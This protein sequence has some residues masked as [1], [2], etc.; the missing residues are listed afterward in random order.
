MPKF[1]SPLNNIT[2]T[3]SNEEYLSIRLN[4]FLNLKDMPKSFYE[5][6]KG[7]IKI[8]EIL[9]ITNAAGLSSNMFTNTLVGYK[10]IINWLRLQVHCNNPYIPAVTSYSDIN[11]SI[12]DTLLNGVESFLSS[13]ENDQ[14]YKFI[15]L[16]QATIVNR[17]FN[18]VKS[19]SEILTNELEKTYDERKEDIV[20]KSSSEVSIQCL[21][22]FSTSN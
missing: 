7:L 15:K 18:N 3:S 1:Y 9:R 13:L 22:I 19:Q 4:N 2:D 10:N 11:E 5:A 12:S 14:N 8:R 17:D 16:M 6:I 21:K 20:E